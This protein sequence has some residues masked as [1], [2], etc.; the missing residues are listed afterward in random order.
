MRRA[1]AIILTLAFA[2]QAAGDAIAPP[3]PA[4]HPNCDRVL[5]EPGVVSLP[6]DRT[7]STV[8]SA[9]IGPAQVRSELAAVGATALDMA[10]STAT[11]ENLTA[12]D[13]PAD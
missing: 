12:V 11:A 5:Q 9:N 2:Q 13:I 3:S 8:A 1:L 7:A 6:S 10:T 4:Y